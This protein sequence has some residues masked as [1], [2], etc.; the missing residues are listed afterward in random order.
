VNL[1]HEGAWAPSVTSNEAL[2]W[3]DVLR[4]D[5]AAPAC[6]IAC[7]VAFNHIKLIVA[8][9][10]I[11]HFEGTLAPQNLFSEDSLS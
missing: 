4:L 1:N 11:L 9:T 6:S 3:I 5:R 10:L 2:S 7:A 8:Y